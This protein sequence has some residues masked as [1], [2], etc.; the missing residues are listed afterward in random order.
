[1]HVGTMLMIFGGVGLAACLIW[2]AVDSAGRGRRRQGYAEQA[3][4][5][6]R[7]VPPSPAPQYR[8]TAAITRATA[9]VLAAQRRGS[10]TGA[11]ASTGFCPA[12]GTPLSAGAAF[13]RNCGRAIPRG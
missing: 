3:A 10:A 9:D 11:P 2:I 13:C 12:C 4:Q 8:T 7:A 1:M 6:V 5:A